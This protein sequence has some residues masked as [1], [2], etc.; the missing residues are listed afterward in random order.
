MTM[1]ENATIVTQKHFE[2]LAQRTV[3]EDGFLKELKSAARAAGI[4]AIWIEPAQASFLQILLRLR[5]ARDV[6]EV[7]TLAGYSAIVMAR[8]LPA[9]GHVRTIEL[10]DKHAAFAEDWISRSDVA[11]RVTVLRGA[12]ATVLA[13]FADASADAAFLDADKGGYPVYLRECMRILRRGGLMMV[14][15]AF[16]FGQLFADTPTDPEVGAVR[17]FNDII[18]KQPGLQS[19]IVPMGDGCWVGVKV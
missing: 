17:A 16:A 3:A 14:D 5:G 6:V 4:P 19:V 10:L 13:T 15:N 8:A 18:A 11:D 7:G 12:G 9:D 1:S 2:Y